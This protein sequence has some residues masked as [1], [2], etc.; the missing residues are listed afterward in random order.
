MS[1]MLNYKKLWIGEGYGRDNPVEDAIN[2]VFKRAEQLGIQKD[3]AEV[4]I[5]ETFVAIASGKKFSTTKCHCGCGIDKSGTDAVHSMFDEL[6][7]TN[8]AI[9]TQAAEL[10]ER[11]FNAA[12]M[13]HMKRENEAYIAENMKPN[14]I[15]RAFR[16]VFKRTATGESV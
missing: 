8:R 16:R 2:A 7:R 12:I 3:I 4:V 9:K 5:N 13:G 14:F 11:R 10:V 1:L 6:T 15:V